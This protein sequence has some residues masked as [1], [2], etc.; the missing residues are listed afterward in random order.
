MKTTSKTYNCLRREKIQLQIS[1]NKSSPS[2][3]LPILKMIIVKDYYSDLE[4]MSN[5]RPIKREN[6]D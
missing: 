1:T 3:F 6:T 2:L 5:R 4:S